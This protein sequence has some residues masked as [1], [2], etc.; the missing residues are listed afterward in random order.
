MNTTLRGQK[1]RV[2]VAMVL[3]AVLVLLAVA[4]AYA[5]RPV[6]TTSHGGAIPAHRAMSADSTRGS[7]ISR[8][9]YIE[10]HAEV[11]QR[12]GNGSLR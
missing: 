5:L 9:P 6:S 2:T 12:L 10:R 4:L 8:D 1:L 7:T 3:L 11:V